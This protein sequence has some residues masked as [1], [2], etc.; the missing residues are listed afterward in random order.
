MDSRRTSPECDWLQLV[1]YVDKITPFR[2]SRLS[3]LCHRNRTPGKFP[4]AVNETYDGSSFSPAFFLSSNKEGERK[5]DEAEKEVE[6]TRTFPSQVSS[7][8]VKGGTWVAQVVLLK[9]SEK[10]SR[11]VSARHLVSGLPIFPALRIRFPLHIRVI[12]HVP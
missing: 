10:Q 5:E 1:T 12:V 6:G 9:K 11:G 7:I 8:F 3:L 2:R 4:K